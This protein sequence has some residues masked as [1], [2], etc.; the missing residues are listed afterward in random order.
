MP[1]LFGTQGRKALLRGVIALADTVAVTLGPKGR[2]VC[3]EKNFG[4]PLVTKDGV[5][6]AKEVELSDINENMGVTLV[7]E[8]ASKTSEDAGDGTTTSTVLA[9]CVYEEGLKLVEAGMAPVFLKRGMDRAVVDV[10]ERIKGMS[11]EVRS[12]VDLI[13]AVATISANGD[14]EIGD[15]LADTIAKVG[16]DGVINIEEGQKTKTE[17]E[18]T[19]G[20]RFDQGLVATEFSADGNSVTLENPL[21]LVTD[22]RVSA[23][24]PILPLLEAVLESQ[25]GLVIIAPTFEG[26]VI[27]T[28]V[29][30]HLKGSLRSCLVRAPGFGFRQTEYLEDIATHVGATF[31]SQAKGMTFAGCFDKKSY[32]NEEDFKPLSFLGSASSV[33]VTRKDTT[34][35]DGAGNDGDIDQ[36]EEQ[37]RA[38]MRSARS[39]YDKDKLKERLARLLGGICTIKVGAQSDLAMKE[40]K[41]RIEDAL[42]ATRSSL[43][44]GIVAGGGTALLRAASGLSAP[45]DLRGDEAAGYN[46]L[47]NKVCQAP[48]KQLLKNAGEDGSVWI[49]KILESPSHMDGLDINKMVITD[50]LNSG[51]V[52]PAKVVR[53]ALENAVSAAGIMLTT[54]CLITKP[55]GPVGL[56]PNQVSFG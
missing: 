36:R 40:K 45:E 27:P 38:E 35:V 32:A 34:I 39:E 26:N 3:L 24:A 11:R 15:I 41:A 25:R 13:R 6:V 17:V 44:E 29:Q 14:T 51:I 48:I 10:V 9:R 49:H 28:F 43:E 30:N 21:I 12:D 53:C 47:V 8:A 42:S 33:K 16:R 7:R 56:D 18:T 31:I 54:E 19:D 20:M 23:I 1:L 22:H 5:S 52:D 46:L 50:C 2:N 37:L 4:E 55:K